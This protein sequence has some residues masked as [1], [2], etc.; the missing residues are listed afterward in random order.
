MIRRVFEFL[1]VYDKFEPDMRGKLNQG[2]SD[3]ILAMHQ[4][5]AKDSPVKLL[6]RSV[7]AGGWLQNEREDAGRQS[8]AAAGAHAGDAR[9]AGY[10]I[11]ERHLAFPEHDRPGSVRVAAAVARKR[12][13]IVTMPT[14]LIISAQ[15][16][17]TTS[18]YEYLWQDPDIFMSAVKE[19][20][21]FASHARRR[22]TE[23]GDDYIRAGYLALARVEDYEALFEGGTHAL[24]RGEASTIYLLT[25]GCAE[26]MVRNGHLPGGRYRPV[27]GLWK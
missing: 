7:L 15:K 4:F 16:A 23:P 19:P 20:W 10:R 18:M 22:W 17:G 9:K 26:R 11:P 25:E 5:F 1:G 6:V 14:F 3:K 21:H 13:P 2:H 27:W 12:W 8:A 24:A